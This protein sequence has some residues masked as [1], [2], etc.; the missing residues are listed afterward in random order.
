MKEVEVRS[1]ISKERYEELLVFFMKSAEFIKEDYQ[2]T[3][4][5]DCD[6]DLRLQRN[7]YYAKIWLKEGKVHDNLRE[8]TEIE[9]KREDFEDAKELFRL[10]GYKTEIVWHRKRK[11]FLWKDDITVC[12]DYTEG[13][14]YIIELEK[15]VEQEE[16]ERIYNCLVKEMNDLDIKITSK[17]EFQEKFDYYKKNWRKIILT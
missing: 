9:I 14:G 3:I 2:E 10:L 12:L 1:F 17:E 6:K 8:E 5:F 16:G 7:N 4:Y 13:Y 15:I 11:Q